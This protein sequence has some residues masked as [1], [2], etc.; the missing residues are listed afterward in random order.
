MQKRL[1][2]VSLF[3]LAAAAPGASLSEV[4]AQAPDSA[5]APAPAAPELSATP[6]AP[7]SAAPAP[8]ALETAPAA[9]RTIDFG[10]GLKAEIL[11][12]GSGDTA[13]AGDRLTVHYVGWIEHFKSVSDPFQNTRAAGEPL[14]FPLGVGEVIRGWDVGL[15]G[16]KVGE[17]RLLHVPSLLGYGSRDM[18]II[19]PHSDLRFE[20][21]LVSREAGLEQDSLF[22]AKKTAWT[23]LVPGVEI[24]DQTVGTGEAAREGDELSLHYTGWLAGGTR[25]ATTKLKGEPAT[26]LLGAGQVIP[27][28]ELGLA[29]MKAGGVRLMR[30]QPYMA[31]GQASGPRIPP[32]STLLFRVELKE[33]SGAAAG[34]ETDL[35][36]DLASVA[37][38]DGPQGMKIAVVAPGEGDEARPG[39]TVSVHYT[40]WLVDGTKFDTS[41]LRGEPFVFTLGSGQVIV[42]WDLGVEGMKP[43]EK[44]LLRIPAKLGYGSR[45]AGSIPPDAELVFAV[46]LVEAR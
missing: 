35:F 27:G 2:L 39:S 6:S 14:S 28:W 30:I 7:D 26:V 41:R 38:T 13:R 43:G 9:R 16:M 8:A 24:F 42:G 20:V 25:F 37:W 10:E 3:A 11:A 45:G 5:S 36:P 29:G 32:F 34:D 21:E 46:E 40:G 12:E 4:P 23:Q 17:R 1:V 18:G 44:R 19:P 33:R 31:Y 15:A 22:D